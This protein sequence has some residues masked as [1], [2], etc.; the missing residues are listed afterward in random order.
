VKFYEALSGDYDDMTNFRQ[1]LKTEKAVVGKWIER[2]RVASAVDAACGT[3]L[4][5]ILLASLGVRTV[6]VDVS[7]PMLKKAREHAAEA[8]VRLSWVQAPME[9]LARHVK[10]P[11][12]AVFCLGNSIPH[13]TMKRDLHAALK[14]FSNCLSPGGRVVLELLNYDRVL[15]REERVVNITRRGKTEYVRFY[16]FGRGLLRFNVL[17]IVEEDGQVRHDLQSTRLRPYRK[18]DLADALRACGFSRPAFFGDMRFQPFNA[19]TSPNLVLVAK[20]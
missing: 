5:A 1:R 19:R 4:Y 17:R 2:L 15:S 6:G 12:D 7:A 10:G 16:D 11:F 3:G 13:L 18:G 20:S 8:G 9:R 14:Q